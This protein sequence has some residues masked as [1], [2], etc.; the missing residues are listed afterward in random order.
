MTTR[1]RRPWDENQR[2]RFTR[3]RKS[4]IRWLW[5]FSA[6]YIR[7]KTELD[8]NIRSRRSISLCF[9]NT[10]APCID[11]WPPYCVQRFSHSANTCCWQNTQKNAVWTIQ[12]VAVST[13]HT[14]RTTSAQLS[15]VV[16]RVL[17]ITKPVTKEKS[18][19]SF[20]R[21]DPCSM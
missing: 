10:A 20:Y 2:S 16:V 14:W 17:R 11:L 19:P 5:L 3:I 15:E 18:F 12:C 8:Y 21:P 9:R 1:S 4:A 6:C 7:R 13:G